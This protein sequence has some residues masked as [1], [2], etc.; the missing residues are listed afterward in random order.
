MADKY[1]G[2]AVRE[3]TSGDEARVLRLDRKTRLIQERMIQAIFLLPKRGR[4]PEE[5][6]AE[7]H[8]IRAPR[9]AAAKLLQHEVSRRGPYLEC[10]RCGQFWLSKRIDILENLGPCLGHTIYGRPERDRPWIIPIG[11]KAIRWGQQVLH[12]SHKAKWVRGVMFCT[13]CGAY[14]T[15]GHTFKKLARECQPN[16]KGQYAL[17]TKGLS[18]GKLRPGLK[19]WP[20]SHNYPGNKRITDYHFYPEPNWHH[21]DTDLDDPRS[22]TASGRQ[23]ADKVRDLRLRRQLTGSTKRPSQ[24]VARPPSRPQGWNPHSGY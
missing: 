18:Q 6:A 13:E 15:S 7:P 21:T 4:H 22:L 3:V 5:P 23:T 24:S 11:S 12:P 2:E 1:A 16:P 8:T 17:Q 10:A 9:I 19:K 14:S 20:C